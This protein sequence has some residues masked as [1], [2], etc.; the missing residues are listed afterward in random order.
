[1]LGVYHEQYFD[2][3]IDEAIN[4][5]GFQRLFARQAPER[6]SR[7]LARSPRQPQVCATTVALPQN[8]LLAERSDMDHIVEAIRKIQVHSAALAKACIRGRRLGL[9]ED[10]LQYRLTA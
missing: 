2:G 1:V 10:L 7:E 4:S 8:L 6:V 5:R 9:L 3:L